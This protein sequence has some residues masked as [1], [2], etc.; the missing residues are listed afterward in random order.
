MSDAVDREL[1]TQDKRLILA[2][3]SAARVSV[4][5]AAGLTFEQ[6]VAGVDEESIRDSLRAEGATTLKQADTLAETKAM[7][8]S[9]KHRGIVLGAD[10][11]LDL[12]GVGMDKPHD[13]AEAKSHLQRL[14]GK[15]HT[16]QTAMVACIDGSPVWRHVAQPKLRMRN[17]SDSFIDSYLEKVGEAA[18][19][20]VGAYQIE[21]LGAQLFDRID[22]DQFSIMGVPL[23]P[24]M[25][26]LRDRE[27]LP[28]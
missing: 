21:G 1:A 28:Q 20:S 12:E 11:M 24:L 16:L 26:W 27:V 22:G 23:L 9:S 3:K 7:K 25:N 15:T 4:L 10:Q 14:R 2:S 6:I 5:K 8:V 13:M 19:H 17:F 18:L